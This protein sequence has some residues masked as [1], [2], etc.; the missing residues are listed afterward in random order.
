M[1]SGK[2]PDAAP[3]LTCLCSNDKMKSIVKCQGGCGSLSTMITSQTDTICK[4][5][6]AFVEQINSMASKYGGGAAGAGFPKAG[7]AGAGSAG[8][9]GI[10]KSSAEPASTEPSST[11]APKTS[12]SPKTGQTG[13]RSV[14]EKRSVRYFAA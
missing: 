14:M 6:K 8:A 7:S 5:P 13:K 12:K 3:F 4:D 9:G 2:L 10:P 1:T 11:V